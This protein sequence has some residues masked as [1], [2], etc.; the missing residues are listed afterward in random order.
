M[1]WHY[2]DFSRFWPESSHSHGVAHDHGHPKH[3]HHHDV[4]HKGH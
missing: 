1:N 3:E 4:H 2:P